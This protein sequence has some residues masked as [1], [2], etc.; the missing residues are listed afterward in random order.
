LPHIEPDEQF[1]AI[2]QVTELVGTEARIHAP[3]ERAWV[4]V[5]GEF[6]VEDWATVRSGGAS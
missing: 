3:R 2:G 5:P 6:E 1:R 4:S